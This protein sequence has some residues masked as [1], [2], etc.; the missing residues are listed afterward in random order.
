MAGDK[1]VVHGYEVL[2]KLVNVL[3]VGVVQLWVAAGIENCLG[4]VEN[5]GV[6]G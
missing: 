1:F 5:D 4:V 6:E 2:F 3:A